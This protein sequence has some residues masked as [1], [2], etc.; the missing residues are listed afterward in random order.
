MKLIEIIL[1]NQALTL[2]NK[3]MLISAWKYQIKYFN[4]EKASKQPAEFGNYRLSLL[5]RFNKSSNS[6]DL[7]K[8]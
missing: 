5:L 8:I 7:R 3:L 6:N 2:I 1:Y 4:S